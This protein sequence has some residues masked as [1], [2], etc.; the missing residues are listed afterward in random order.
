MTEDVC[1]AHQYVGTER[2][3]WGLPGER[4]VVAFIEPTKVRH[5]VG[6]EPLPRVRPVQ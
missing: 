1:Q 4:R 6:V 2:F 5:V 3:E